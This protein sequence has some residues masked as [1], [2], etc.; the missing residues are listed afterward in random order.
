M[1]LLAVNAV[2]S[3]SHHIHYPPP[4]NKALGS[5]PVIETQLVRSFLD[6]G[7]EQVQQLQLGDELVLIKPMDGADSI[8]Q[9]ILTASNSNP[10]PPPSTEGFY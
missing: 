5:Y 6:K 1:P 9:K 4:S 10:L 3:S 7:S 2:L 8:G